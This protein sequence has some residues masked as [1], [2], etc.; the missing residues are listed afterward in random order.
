MSRYIPENLSLEIE[1]G[2][3]YT[4]SEIGEATIKVLKLNDVDRIIER[5][6]LR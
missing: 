3:L 6:L 1:N 4:K 2:M 5:Q